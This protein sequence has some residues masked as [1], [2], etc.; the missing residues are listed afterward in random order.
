[1][2]NQELIE[3]FYLQSTEGIKDEWFVSDIPYWYSYVVNL[4]KHLQ[5]TYL[6]VI[7]ESQV[8]NG[9]FDQYFANG[10]GQFA[11]ETIEA[12]IEIGAFKKS[13]LLENAFNLIND[14]SISDEE[15]RKELLNKT[16]KKLFKEE[17]LNGPFIKLDDIYYD[18]EDENIGDLLADYLR[19]IF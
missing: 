1:M 16:L 6:T 4:P 14:D 7:L 9:G 12:L 10:Y 8:F 13:N 2:N 3:K 11:R 5:T 19:K 18:I 15:F 17:N